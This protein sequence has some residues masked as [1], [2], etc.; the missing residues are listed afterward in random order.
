[1]QNSCEEVNKPERAAT[2]KTQST[3]SRAP[4]LPG[5]PDAEHHSGLLG[6]PAHLVQRLREQR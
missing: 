1:M 6:L 2:Q 5:I 3:G 4:V